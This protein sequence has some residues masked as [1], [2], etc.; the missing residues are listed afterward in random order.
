MVLDQFHEYPINDVV[1][2]FKSRKC[3]VV[4]IRTP[5]L[6]HYNLPKSYLRDM[7][8]RV[9][10]GTG[11]HFVTAKIVKVDRTVFRWNNID[12]KND[13][14]TVTKYQVTVEV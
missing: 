11:L 10:R 13:Q 12:K 14:I 6:N 9:L 2:L 4:F 8:G 1:K 3:D 7:V 5:L